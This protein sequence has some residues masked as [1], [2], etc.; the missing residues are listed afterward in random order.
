MT[1]NDYKNLDHIN[2]EMLFKGFDG[3][4]KYQSVMDLVVKNVSQVGSIRFLL[5][6]N[7]AIC[8]ALRYSDEGPDLSKVKVRFRCNERAL[9]VNVRSDNHG[10]DVST[11]LER[12]RN[13][14]NPND[15][16]SKL[17]NQTRGRGIWIMATGSKKVIFN[18]SGNEITLIN[19]LSDND[20]DVNL[21]SKISI[22]PDCKGG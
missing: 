21:L 7:E 6:V 14:N 1:Q 19:Y 22:K 17:K 16:W 11:Y 8:N 2:L 5:A 4:E 10:F 12:L 15:C 20:Q 9:I 3:F 18:K 13:I